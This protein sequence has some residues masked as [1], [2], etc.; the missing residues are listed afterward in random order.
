LVA[1]KTLMMVFCQA[2]SFLALIQAPVTLATR[3][4]NSYPQ[5][6]VCVPP[7]HPSMPD[8]VYINPPEANSENVLTQAANAQ[9][10]Y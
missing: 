6:F 8:A 9:Q 7:N 10:T 5:R 2:E 4:S 1:I 3:W